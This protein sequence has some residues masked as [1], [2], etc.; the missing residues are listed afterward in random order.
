MYELP[1]PRLVP[2]PLF[3]LSNETTLS[4]QPLFPFAL[5][6]KAALSRASHTTCYVRRHHPLPCVALIVMDE[7][8]AR[9]DLGKLDEEKPV[10][11]AGNP[12]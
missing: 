6:T 9:N 8:G 2:S 12:L 10:L 4:P 1:L 11:E 7:G 5:P 3:A